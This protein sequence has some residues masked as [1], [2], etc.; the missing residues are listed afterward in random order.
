MLKSQI[1]INAM[2]NN[3]RNNVEKNSTGVDNLDSRLYHA[4][5]YIAVLF[6]V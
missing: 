4:T 2:F 1:V 3:S 6:I 5:L